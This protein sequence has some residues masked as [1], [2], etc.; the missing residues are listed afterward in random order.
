MPL[1]TALAKYC[2]STVLICSRLW[3]VTI[4]SRF[5]LLSQLTVPFHA[6]AYVVIN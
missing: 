2:S 4:G 6:V 1:V 5:I 3:C